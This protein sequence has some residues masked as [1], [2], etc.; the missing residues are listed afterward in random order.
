[1]CSPPPKARCTPDALL[2]ALSK[3]SVWTHRRLQED[4]SDFLLKLVH[5]LSRELELTGNPSPLDHTILSVE[6]TYDCASCHNHFSIHNTDSTLILKASPDAT[7]GNGVL[8]LEHLL[9]TAYFPEEVEHTCPVCN[10]NA[11]VRQDHPTHTPAT[12][13]IVLP[14]CTNDANHRKDNQPIRFPETGL[15]LQGLLSSN[16]SPTNPIYHLL[17]MINHRGTSMRGGHYTAY[18][19]APGRGWT[20]H[21]DQ[22]VTGDVRLDFSGTGDPAHYRD[23]TVL[24]YTSVPPT[25]TVAPSGSP[26]IGDASAGRVGP[27]A[28]SGK[29]RRRSRGRSLDPDVDSAP[30]SDVDSDS[31]SSTPSARKKLRP[32]EPSDFFKANMLDEAAASD[33]V[34]SDSSGDSSEYVQPNQRK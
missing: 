20:H 27:I 19:K 13:F 16:R 6:T 23:A 15:D 3:E 12:L 28:R 30:G 26:G 24:L 25:P 32:R 17:G 4:A 8:T 18:T 1:M 11:A 14:R 22:T 5:R 33:S 29:G 21:N 10:H 2:T 7:P 34:G 31:G 9:S